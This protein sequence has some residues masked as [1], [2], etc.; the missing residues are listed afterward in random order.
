MSEKN[1]MDKAV[2]AA[3]LAKAAAMIAKAALAGGLYGA[4]AAAAKEFAPSLI[5]WSLI[6]LAVLMVMPFLI[7]CALPN[8]FFRYDSRARRDITAMT[9]K[10]AVIEQAYTEAQAL[11]EGELERQIEAHLTTYIEENPYATDADE[12]EI[13]RTGGI[14]EYWYIAISSVAHEQD[15]FSM[16]EDEVKKRTIFSFPFMFGIPFVSWIF[17][18]D[19]QPDALPLKKL[20][21]DI[22]ELEPEDLMT[23][24]NFTDEQKNWARLIYSTMADDQTIQPGNPDYVYGDGVDYGNIQYTE[25]QTPVTYYN[26]G[27][28]RWGNKLYGKVDTIKVAGCG[29]TA[30][31][32]VVSSLTDESITPDMVADW[33]VA[34]GH[35]C[36]GSGSYHSL[37]P[38]GAQHYGLTVEGAKHNEA[39]KIVDALASGKL[40]IAIMT[41]GHFTTSGHFIV[42]RGITADGKVLVADPASVQRSE[43][44]WDLK[45]VLGETRRD[46]AAGGPVWIISSDE[47]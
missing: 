9:D 14:N 39:Q 12:V 28:S 13:N 26:Q 29:P 35:R 47:Q 5:K 16:N 10:A 27:D 25:G 46:A 4:A 38:Q 21:V 8:I 18:P 11:S 45:L 44:E 36:E 15:L 40:A 17:P 31:A 20:T 32:M 41:K 7:I 43:Q 22:N 34:N 30:L 37:I 2:N 3:R 33:S 24:L 19:D 42:L 1:G 23:E 6:T